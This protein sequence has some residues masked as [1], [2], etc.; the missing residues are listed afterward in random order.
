MLR[1]SWGGTGRRPAAAR[2]T[3]AERLPTGRG[4]WCSTCRAEADGLESVFEANRPKGAEFVGTD[5]RDLQTSQPR[6]FLADHRVT[7]P[8]CYDP[9]G[10]LLLKFPTGTLNPGAVPTT[11]VLD[12]RGR[13]VARAR[14]D[15]TSDQ[16]TC[17]LAPVL[18][19][20]P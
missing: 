19:E 14:K 1:P 2:C 9:T 8:S 20:Q 4:A 17:M 12:R 6:A 13:I 16:M 7:Y 15:L 3:A 10:D 11:V 18:A 5:S